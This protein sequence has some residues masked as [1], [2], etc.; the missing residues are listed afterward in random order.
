M[1]I[2]F[3]PNTFCDPIGDRNIHWPA[4]EMNDSVKSVIM[5]IARLDSNSLY[6]NLMLGAGSAVTGMVTL[7]AAATYLHHLNVTV[8]GKFINSYMALNC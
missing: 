4:G 2:N 5:V 3:N 6:E 8:S 1:G 7:L